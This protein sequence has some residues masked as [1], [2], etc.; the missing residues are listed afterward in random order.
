MLS[1][2]ETIIEL[3]STHPGLL[4]EFHFVWLPSVYNEKEN[5]CFLDQQQP[6]A[7][8]HTSC[9]R[10]YLHGRNIWGGCR[11]G[12]EGITQT[13]IFQR[14]SQMKGYTFWIQ[15]QDW[16]TAPPATEPRASSF[17]TLKDGPPD[18]QK[19]GFLGESQKIYLLVTT[20]E[21]DCARTSQFSLRDLSVFEG[22]MGFSFWI[23]L[24]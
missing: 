6:T 3:D 19:W 23:P 7:V 13:R 9:S 8:I 14:V 20:K 5:R 15:S 17:L 12:T 1:V 21:N 18:S 22:K 10:R 4:F 24:V 11:D 2:L 16:I